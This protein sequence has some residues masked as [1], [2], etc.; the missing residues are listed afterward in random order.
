MIK[1]TTKLCKL[2]PVQREV[3]LGL[4]LG[5][6]HLETLDNGR[7]YKLCVEQ[8][9]ERHA[10]YLFHLFEI[11]SNITS[12]KTP[13]EKKKKKNKNTLFFRTRAHPGLR[14]YANLFYKDRQK[15]IPKNI[16]RFLT[17]RVL[18]YW[19]MDDGALKG[20]NRSGK[21]FHT[22]GF[23]YEE[24]L[25]LRDALIQLGI[26]STVQKQNRTVGQILKT[27]YI[28]YITAKGDKIFTEKIKPYVLHCMY[29]KLLNL[30]TIA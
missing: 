14:F 24:V 29:Y 25:V 12:Q 20:M 10:E 19:Y 16:H 9:K 6:G 26:E 22:E 23:S 27:Y 1:T 30:N 17:D 4:M 7:T 18:A 13:V 5:D 3:I 28:I 21:R 11:F 15:V 8:S 2:T